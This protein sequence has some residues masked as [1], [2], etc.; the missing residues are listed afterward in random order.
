MILVYK[1]NMEQLVILVLEEKWVLREMMAL[2]VAPVLR[3]LK[4]RKV[5]LV[6]AVILVKKEKG[7]FKV[8]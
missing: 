1:V 8:I 2:K 7:V 5:T 3:A 6:H 4:D